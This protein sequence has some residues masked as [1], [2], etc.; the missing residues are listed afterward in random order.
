M[1]ICNNN[2]GNPV[3]PPQH[4]PGIVTRVPTDFRPRRVVQQTAFIRRPCSGRGC[5]IENVIVG[6]GVPVQ[7]RLFATGLPVLVRFS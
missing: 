2:N 1:V 4:L 3:R 5:G 7:Q 6:C